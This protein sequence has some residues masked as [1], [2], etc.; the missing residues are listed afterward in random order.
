MSWA[1]VVS[2]CLGSTSH[3]LTESIFIFQRCQAQE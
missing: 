3:G 2:F 1:D